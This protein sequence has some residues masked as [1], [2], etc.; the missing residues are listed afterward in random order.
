MGYY[1]ENDPKYEGTMAQRIVQRQRSRGRREE[2]PYERANR[3]NRQVSAIR[4][5]IQEVADSKGYISVRNMINALASEVGKEAPEVLTLE[6]ELAERIE[7]VLSDLEDEI[8]Q[9]D[10]KIHTFQNMH[11][12]EAPGELQQLEAN[13]D[14]ELRALLMRMKR[15]KAMETYNRRYIGS[16]LA[17]ASRAQAI[18]VQK[19]CMIPEYSDL[20]SERQRQTALDKSQ[21]DEEKVFFKAREERISELNHERSKLFMRGYHLRRALRQITATSHYYGQAGE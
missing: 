8:K 1:E 19:L 18:A 15:G 17:N 10:D 11:H 3:L 16:V 7:I 14:R 21:S 13:S 6:K 12:E 5:N 2:S 4:R 9:I 20:L